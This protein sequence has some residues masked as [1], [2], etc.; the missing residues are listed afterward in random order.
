VFGLAVLPPWIVHIDPTMGR[1]GHRLKHVLNRRQG[2]LREFLWTPEESD[3]PFFEQAD[4]KR[5]AMNR[6]Y[7]S[8]GGGNNFK[9]MLSA[10]APTGAVPAP[11]K[12]TGIPPAYAAARL[13]RPVFF[14]FLG[15]PF[16][17]R[18]RS[19]TVLSFFSFNTERRTI[20]GY[21]AM[22]MIRK[23]QVE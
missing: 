9:V 6:A 15:Q 13:C 12:T 17:P 2:A 4:L 10:D 11:M 21:E 3:S 19:T 1:F 22:N 16:I 20:G 14:Q 7:R 18:D 23:G 5:Q 8:S